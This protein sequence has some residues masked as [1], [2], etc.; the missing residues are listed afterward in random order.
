[1]KPIVPA[2]LLRDG[3]AASDAASPR[4]DFA[5]GD[6]RGI[7]MWGAGMPETD[8]QALM[9][10]AP[11]DEPRESKESQ[12]LRE[13]A[14]RDRVEAAL[15]LLDEPERLVVML[16]FYQGLGYRGIASVLQALNEAGMYE[17][18]STKTTIH[19]MG[20][21]QSGLEKLKEILSE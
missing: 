4:Q 18:P 20:L 5:G 16:H 10:S 13:Q 15:A 1:M 12:A 17:G 21:L 3:T 6:D 11:H 8:L 19:R 2:R 9:E 14:I 7:P